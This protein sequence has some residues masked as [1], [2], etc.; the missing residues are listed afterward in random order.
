MHINS[1]SFN[2]V[3]TLFKAINLVYSYLYYKILYIITNI[4]PLYSL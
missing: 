3:V 4:K 2:L 1:F